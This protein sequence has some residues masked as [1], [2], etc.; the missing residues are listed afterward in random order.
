MV[1]P[2]S[3]HTRE[4][5]L[6][7]DVFPDLCPVPEPDHLRD[8]D[9]EPAAGGEGAGQL[10]GPPTLHGQTAWGEAQLLGVHRSLSDFFMCVYNI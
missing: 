7:C 9:T 8:P 3:R 4:E 5:K 2:G 10:P 1:M 6:M